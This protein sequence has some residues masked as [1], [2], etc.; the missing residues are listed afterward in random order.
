VE[1]PRL[2]V[3][4]SPTHK[5]VVKRQRKKRNLDATTTTTLDNELMDI[6]WKNSPIDPSDNLTRLS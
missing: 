5:A 4:Y 1:I 6:I 2:D 3:F